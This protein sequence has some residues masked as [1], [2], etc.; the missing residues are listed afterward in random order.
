[1]DSDDEERNH[2]LDIKREFGITAAENVF[3]NLVKQ[4]RAERDEALKIAATLQQQR[5]FLRKCVLDH[6]KC[7][8]CAENDEQNDP[9]DSEPFSQDA[10]QNIDGQLRT[11]QERSKDC[12]D[13]HVDMFPD[14]ND[15]KPVSNDN[16]QTQ[17]VE[18]LKFLCAQYQQL[19]LVTASELSKLE[20][21]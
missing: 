2:L 3:A 19:A 8:S 17:R 11:L 1:M 13:V 20:A 4:A 9:G 6:Q 7:Q 21:S 10:Q 18:K 15:S 14:K 16:D 5:N 12:F